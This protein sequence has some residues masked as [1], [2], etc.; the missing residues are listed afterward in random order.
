MGQKRICLDLHSNGFGQEPDLHYPFL[1]PSAFLNFFLVNASLVTSSNI[2]ECLKQSN[3]S[4]YVF[5][6]LFLLQ[7]CLYNF[8]EVFLIILPLQK[9]CLILLL[10]YN[11][12]RIISL[13][14]LIGLN[15]PDGIFERTI[16][17]PCLF[18]SRSYCCFLVS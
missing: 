15:I 16:S 12:E 10:Q 14:F 13:P 18:M 2:R 5:F 11:F 6:S 7:V 8:R 9:T 1:F 17:S 4:A 3:G